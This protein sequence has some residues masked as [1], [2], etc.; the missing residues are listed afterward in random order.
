[1]NRKRIINSLQA[2]SI[3]SFFHIYHF[4]HCFATHPFF[5]RHANSC[6][7]TLLQGFYGVNL[8][9][10]WEFHAI[11]PSH[12]LNSL[13]TWSW[14]F[15]PNVLS[16]LSDNFSNNVTWNWFWLSELI[17]SL[18]NLPKTVRDLKIWGKIQWLVIFYPNFSTLAFFSCVLQ[19][20][21]YLFLFSLKP[22]VITVITTC[23]LE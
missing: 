18:V 22:T 7:I 14:V 3:T 6:L 19:H 15:C 4:K 9:E 20:C 12:P 2:W 16:D 23:L 10:P 11:T 13:H 8:F 21:C 17:Q 1:M 5:E